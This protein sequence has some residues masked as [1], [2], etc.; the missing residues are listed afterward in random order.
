MACV[1]LSDDEPL[2]NE[3][4]NDGLMGYLLIFLLLYVLLDVN[5]DLNDDVHPMLYLH[6]FILLIYVVLLDELYLMLL[7][8]I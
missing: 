6:E 4:P 8:L 3:L 2:I 7:I 5:D 1:H